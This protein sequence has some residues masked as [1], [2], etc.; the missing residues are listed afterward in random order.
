MKAGATPSVVILGCGHLAWHLSSF[1]LSLGIRPMVINHRA[2]RNL[3][4]FQNELGLATAS[5]LSK[6]PETADYYFLCVSD[7]HV[8]SLSKRLGA[9][10]DQALVLHCSGTLPLEEIQLSSS[11]RAIFYPLQSF[12]MGDK[13]DWTQIP[14]L[15]EAA[16]PRALKNLNKLAKRFPGKRFYPAYAERLRLHFCAVLVSNFTNLLY[17]EAAEFL[18][19]AGQ[20]PMFQQL[21]PL[22]LKTAQKV[23]HLSPIAAQTGPAKRGDQPV[24]RLHKSLIARDKELLRLYNLLS[25]RIAFHQNT[26]HA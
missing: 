2:N 1:L 11:R 12:T 15:L 20:G 17:T 4:R 26:K 21:L 13:V 18:K 14:L 25:K 23:E 8:K 10:S 7:R 5:E 3:K 24:M 22:I 16:N 19:K 6:L 9:I